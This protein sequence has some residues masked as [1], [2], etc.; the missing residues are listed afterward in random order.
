[1]ADLVDKGEAE[2]QQLTQKVT[3]TTTS[4]SVKASVWVG[5]GVAAAPFKAVAAIYR[6]LEQSINKQRESGQ[7]SLK[8]FTQIAEGKRE[9]V[10]IDDRAVA[11][12]LE[13]ELRRHGVVWSVETHRDGSRTFHVKGKDAELIQHALTV[14]A[15]RVDEKLARNAPELQSPREDQ[16]ITE[17]VDEEPVFEENQPDRTTRLVDHGSAPYQHDEKASQSYFVTIEQN[18]VKQTLWGVDLERAV[19]QSGAQIGD[20]ISIENVGSMPV[21][22]PD[23]TETHRNTWNVQVTEPQERVQQQEAGMSIDAHGTDELREDAPSV[24]RAEPSETPTREDAVAP[25]RTPEQADGAVTDRGGHSIEQQPAITR[26]EQR[27]E[28]TPRDRTRAHAAEKIDK[29]VKQRKSEIEQTKTRAKKRT[30]GRSAT[31]DPQAHKSNRR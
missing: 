20:G 28:A 22:L 10:S 14:A 24:E 16:Q 7:V 11:K 17:R 6:S 21:T 9:L 12:E 15:E 18:D 19:S 2:L 29:N 1:M 4:A 27:P 13:R 25:T 31:D 5:K 3:M 30:P 8:A 26:S 23:G